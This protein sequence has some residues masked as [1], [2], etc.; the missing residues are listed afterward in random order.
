MDVRE[1]RQKRL[2]SLWEVGEKMVRED[3]FKS[4][5]LF[6][7]LLNYSQS[8]W[9]VTRQVAK[10]Y[11][12]LTYMRL[13]SQYGTLSATTSPSGQ[14][15]ESASESKSEPTTSSTAATQTG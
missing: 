10:D 7:A 1:E 4:T 12:D 8:R 15:N 13:T 11:A 5:L 2:L 3:G 14:R 9:G 6:N